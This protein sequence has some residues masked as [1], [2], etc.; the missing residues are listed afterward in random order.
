[1]RS[2]GETKSGSSYPATPPMR[3]FT[4][5]GVF[6]EAAAGVFGASDG[7]LGTEANVTGVDF[8][9]MAFW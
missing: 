2:V 8:D 7:G 3:N 5:F 6:A 1:M 4:E 9:P